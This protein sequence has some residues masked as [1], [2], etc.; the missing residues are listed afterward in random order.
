VIGDYHRTSVQ[1]CLAKK[2]KEIAEQEEIDF[3]M[4]TGDKLYHSDEIKGDHDSFWD[5]Y[6]ANVFL[7]GPYLK[8]LNKKGVVDAPKKNKDVIGDENVK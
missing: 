8:S 4:N 3:I 6:W 7:N 5:S 1:Q 2:M